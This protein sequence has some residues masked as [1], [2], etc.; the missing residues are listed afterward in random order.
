MRIGRNPLRAEMVPQP[1][2]AVLCV[3]THLP[4]QE[5]YHA[6]RLEVIQLCLKTMEANTG[7]D[8][9]LLSIMVW[10]NGSCE[11]LRSWLREEY[12]PDILV[13]SFNLGKTLAMT[14]MFRMF[15]P[16]TMICYSDDDMLFYPGWLKKS[17]DLFNHFPN[18]GIISCYPVRT[19]FMW[20]CKYTLEWG[21]KNGTV[22]KGRFMPEEWDRDYSDSVGQESYEAYLERWKDCDEYVITYKGMKAYGTAHH[23]QFIGIAGILN[24]VAMWDNWA[25]ADMKPF[26]IWF[27]K[28]GFLRLTT[29]ERLSQHI[30]NQIDDDIRK[31]LKEMGWQM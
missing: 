30:G 11:A 8:R 1:K 21:K 20:G 23:C 25:M 19:Q 16:D 15:R 13:E 17:L 12:K 29:M 14:Y 7:V 22:E 27:D 26:D 3:V 10:D 18:S 6:D 9:N 28:A 24:K 4:N 5:Q 2:K 31:H